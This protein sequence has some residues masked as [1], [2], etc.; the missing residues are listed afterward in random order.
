MA[1]SKGRRFWSDLALI[2]LGSV[3]TFAAFPTAWSP[4]LN[5]FWLIWASHVPILWVLRDKSPRQAFKWGLVAGTLI[6][7]GGYYWIASMLQT[8]GQL[9]F[10]VAALGLL[11]HS[12]QLGLIWAVWAWM[13]NRIGNTTSLGA[14]WSVPLVMVAVEFAMPRIFP[15]YMGN[16]QF[17]FPLVMQICD[18]FGV[19]AVT[20]LIYRVNAVGFLWLRAR[21]EG[22]QP[23]KRAT[24]ITAAMLG[25]TFVYGGV[26]MYR[27]DAIAAEAAHLEVG[28]V[29]GDVG[30]FQRETMTKRRD[31]L[32]IQQNLSAELEQ[33]GAELIVW[34][35]SSYRA[36]YLPRN[37]TRFTPSKAPLVADWNEDVRRS[38]PYVDRYSPIRGF[39]TPLIF[40]STALL[41][42]STP[43]WRGDGNQLPFNT[44]WLLDRDGTVRGT[45]DKIY[46]LV[47]GEYVPFA[48]HIPWVYDLIP[49]AGNLE[50]GTKTDV[51]EADLWPGKGPVRF[52]ML[53]C[54]EGLLSGF[55][56]R[57][58]ADQ[59]PH[60]LVNIT[61]DDWFGP[62][63][64]RW[65]HLI[66]TIPRAIE[67]RV[68][69]VR[70]TL[71]GVSMFVDPVGR[72]Q[73]YTS[74]AE[75]ERLQ[76]SVPLMQSATVYQVIGDSF[77]WACLLLML[78]FYG[79]GR[80]RRR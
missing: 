64:E 17:S 77:A 9:P 4:D 80:W 76:W 42:S 1:E 36:Q 23:P 25:A 31:H 7:A 10:P 14:E 47:M 6:N 45:Y 3:M 43:R 55:T 54:Y 72:L 18:L 30:I 48:K 62:T 8:F 63:A 16:S 19:S 24:W 79:R 13:I 32:L 38:T 70:A 41:K 65:L 26:Q 50:A 49:A 66:L 20:F 12:L 40:G 46:R 69:M 58:Y 21:R 33:A 34:P 52:G 44:A 74:P 53:I 22:R 60:M 71:T 11:L 61:N 37:A 2:T 57:S 56:R 51:I 5:L 29:E 27:Y 68:P 67:H 39:S 35:E 59:R 28:L 78:G 73:G 15:A 75:P